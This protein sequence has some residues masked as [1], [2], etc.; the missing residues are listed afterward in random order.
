[1]HDG[2]FIIQQGG[3]E[4][5]PRDLQTLRLWV[6]EG[7]ILPESLVFHPHHC[8][9]LPA[10]ALPELGSFGN[11]PQTIVDL[12]TNYRKLVLSVGAQLGVSLVF[13][14]LGPAAILVVP[15]L[16]A[17]VIAIAYYAFHTARALGS[18]SPALWSAAMLVP[19]INLLV[20]AM[21]SSNATEACRKYGI[22]VGFLGPEIT[23]SARR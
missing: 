19:C 10:R 23:D 17:T 9:W 4:F 3:A 18:P 21:L 14:I 7:R 5:R 2:D 6:S 1:M 22:P 8:E 16:G 12:A 20:L 13:W 11:P 15:S